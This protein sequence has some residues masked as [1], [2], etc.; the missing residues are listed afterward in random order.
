MK[1]KDYDGKTTKQVEFYTKDER[2]IGFRL[3]QNA[4][5]IAADD[6]DPNI[7]SEEIMEAE[8]ISRFVDEDGN[9]SFI[10]DLV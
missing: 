10:V 1:V 4:W 9:D 2:Y 5:G 3:G 6:D 7:D 8:V